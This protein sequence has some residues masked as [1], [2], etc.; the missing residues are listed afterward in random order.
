[1]STRS[2]LPPA[3]PPRAG[4]AGFRDEL[5]AAIVPSLAV[6][7][8][9]TGALW[10][11]AA[12]LVSLL[13]TAMLAALLAGRASPAIGSLGVLLAAAILAGAADV[14]AGAWL[15]EVAAGLGIYLP[16]AIVLTS[17][18]VS[19]TVLADA[20]ARGRARRAAARALGA[21]LA[22]LCGV[23]LTGLA[24]E[25][26]GTGTIALPGAA[27]GASVS[28]PGIAGAPARGVLAPSAGLIAAGYLAGLV[29]AFAQWRERR[30]GR[31]GAP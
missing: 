22:F 26:L 5:I 6:A 28:I 19:A 24:R 8:T 25:A 18:P 1:M 9:T 11:S 23:V 16:L 20:E 29:I 30:R 12:V 3:V 13:C 7:L 15:P 2:P 4:P 31:K 14:G 27:G 21:S 17:G 10:L